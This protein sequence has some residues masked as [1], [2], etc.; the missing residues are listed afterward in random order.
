MKNIFIISYEYVD[1][2]T[3]CQKMIQ[4][5]VITCIENSIKLCKKMM[6]IGILS[7]VAIQYWQIGIIWKKYPQHTIM[8]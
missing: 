3:K 7:N 8:F 6:M 2:Y 5:S 1:L 4:S